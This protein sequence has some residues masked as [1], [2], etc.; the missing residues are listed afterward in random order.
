MYHPPAQVFR[1][2]MTSGGEQEVQQP[3]H[4]AQVQEF[5][6][7]HF[8]AGASPRVCQRMATA[9]AGP[10]Q[11]PQSNTRASQ[12]THVQKQ[13]GR[14]FLGENDIPGK[15]FI[16]KVRF[17][18]LQTLRARGY[19]AITSRNARWTFYVSVNVGKNLSIFELKSFLWIWT[20][21]QMQPFVLKSFSGI[22]KVYLLVIS[23]SLLLVSMQRINTS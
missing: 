4:K 5:Q 10:Y 22:T 15:C 13:R 18:L 1:I 9:A 19:F 14:M 6:Q 20:I 21:L 8:P 3:Q 12:R 11:I 2:L 17:S 7:D 23:K 16:F